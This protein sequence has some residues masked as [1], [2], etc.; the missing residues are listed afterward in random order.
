MP[1]F[2][3]QGTAAGCVRSA[4]CRSISPP[5]VGAPGAI[6]VR[7]WQGTHLDGGPVKALL[8]TRTAICMLTTQVRR[9]GLLLHCMLLD[10]LHLRFLWWLRRDYRFCMH[11]R[12]WQNTAQQSSSASP[13]SSGRQLRCSMLIQ[14]CNYHAVKCKL[15]NACNSFCGHACFTLHLSACSAGTL[16]PGMLVPTSNQVHI[17]GGVHPSDNIQ[18]KKCSYRLAVQV[19]DRRPLPDDLVTYAANDVRYLLRLYDR[20][21]AGLPPSSMKKV[22]RQEPSAFLLFLLL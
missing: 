21:S 22:R 3:V 20:L 17:Q 9:A 12:C 10:F 7:L 19:W 14:R 13:L 16:S 6:C 11:C 1:L 5:S 18:L 4:A 15:F 2:A 8:P